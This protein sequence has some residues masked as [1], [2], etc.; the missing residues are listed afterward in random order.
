[1]TNMKQKIT[2]LLF[3]ISFLSWNGNAQTQFWSDTFEDVGAPS[4]GSR[5]PSVSEF[6]CGGPPATAYFKRTDVSSIALQ[7]GTYTGFEGSKF[8]AAEDIDRG[9]T[10]TSNSI[11]ANQQVTWSGINISGK[12]NLSFKGFFA[13]NNLGGWQGINWGA[14]QD[15]VAFEYRIDGGAWVKALAFY[16]SEPAASAASTNTLD[17]DTNGDM[18]GD[19]PSLNYIFTEYSAAIVGTGTVL[20]I[21][22]NCFSNATGVQEIAID[23]FRLFEQSCNNPTVP[24]LAATVN[25][26]CNGASTTLNITGTLNDA[27]QWA[28]YTGSCGGSLVGTTASSTFVV[29][30]TGPSTTYYIRGEGG[31]VTPGTCGSITINVSTVSLTPSSQTDVSCNGGSNGAASVNVATGGVG[32]YT[33]NWTPGNPTGDG[34]TS[35]TGLTAGTWTCTVTDANACTTSVNFTI[36]QPT[37]LALTPASQ[38]NVACNGGSNGAAAVNI[39]TGGAGGYTYNWTP[40]NP[41]GDGT[42]SVTGLTAGTWTC[43]VTDANGCTASQNFTITQPTALSLTPS[44]QTDV[45]CNGG[46]NGAAAVNIATGGA[47]GYTY[48][49]TPGNPT[50]DGTTSVTGLSAGT[51]TCTVTDANGCTASQNFTITQPTAL[52]LTPS[53]QTNVA[54]NGGAN[55]AAA[56]NTATGGA[57]GYTYNWTPGNP[58][59]D[60]TTSVTGLTAGTWTC[61]VTD[62]NGCTASQNFTITQPTA[63]A[64]TPSSQTNVACNGGANGAAAVNTATG[65]A[66]GYTY[67][68]TPG[69]PTGDGTPSVT[70]LTAGTW[71]CTV[72]DANGCTTSQ[73][74]T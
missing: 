11:S 63:L 20:D 28:I 8:W 69:N 10:C 56:V 32:P 65:G 19:G 49:W 74:F 64:L 50:G 24:T 45:A 54:C 42:T 51:W 38:T 67:N 55:G 53:S 70:G 29:T 33:Y 40:G 62:A 48:N 71:T 17:L 46:S 52:A 16:S 66:G 18:I 12:T 27:T 72:T 14:S 57:G 4:S 68:W 39:A 25:P 44:S 34:T 9:P 60:G 6:S 15:F 23:N 37:A 1:M 26:V 21:R 43:T 73:N 59:G 41:I 13:A 36:T 3:I 47:G 35:V 30:P 2:L 31:C 5:T 61:T 22:L 7:S 58:T